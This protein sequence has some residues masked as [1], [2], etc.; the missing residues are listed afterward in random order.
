M[1][2][3]IIICI[4]VILITFVFTGKISAK[5]YLLR[6]EE[7]FAFLKKVYIPALEGI[8]EE[9]GVKMFDALYPEK[10]LYDGTKYSLKDFYIS[11]DDTDT[12]DI[13]K[14]DSEC[15]N[16]RISDYFYIGLT[17]EEY[18][19]LKRLSSELDK[20]LYMQED[21]MNKNDFLSFW[22]D[23]NSNQ[24]LN[25]LAERL[26]QAKTYDLNQCG[27]IN[28]PT[29]KYDYYILIAYPEIFS[30]SDSEN[31]R[32]A[33]TTSVKY[34]KKE[35]EIYQKEKNN[36]DQKKS[37]ENPKTE[38]SLFAILGSITFTGL[39]FIMTIKKAR[40]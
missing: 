22:N 30:L 3:K 34:I 32:F 29:D 13:E 27:S 25:E 18:I 21:E 33:L 11:I 28:Y 8:T 4:L 17:E 5:E 6:D 23:Y 2:R 39:I 40:Q 12:L 24:T 14:F 37:I 19:E 26:G 36:I 7:S 38:D 20:Y 35:E 9:T 16:E 15:R 31:I 10:I 1:K